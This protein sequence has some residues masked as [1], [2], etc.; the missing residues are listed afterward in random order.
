M[1]GK[2]KDA[3]IV[4]PESTQL[5]TDCTIYEHTHAKLAT[6]PNA[7]LKQGNTCVCSRPPRSSSLPMAELNLNMHAAGNTNSSGSPANAPVK[8]RTVAT[9]AGDSRA[10]W[11][12]R[13]RTIAV[14]RYLFHASPCGNDRDESPAVA[15][16]VAVSG[17]LLCSRLDPRWCVRNNTSCSRDTAVAPRSLLERVRNWI[18]CAETTTCKI[19]SSTS[20]Q[21]ISAEAT[22]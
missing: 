20:S 9:F 10:S 12:I 14:N 5:L 13:M 8:P 3:L 11:A 7:T 1:V 18:E 6:D 15:V 17:T 16:L 22:P 4:N 2:M 19:D 21:H